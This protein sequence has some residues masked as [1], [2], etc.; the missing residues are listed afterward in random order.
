MELFQFG[1]DT[2][3]V[4]QGRGRSLPFGQYSSATRICR[5]HLVQSLKRGG[6]M[7][8]PMT[9]MASVTRA[10]ADAQSGPF[11]ARLLRLKSRANREAES[12]SSEE[13]AILHCAK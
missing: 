1:P 2:L 4:E 8:A 12:S 3:R 9:V 11:A 5:I 13:G 6:R 7:T 10:H